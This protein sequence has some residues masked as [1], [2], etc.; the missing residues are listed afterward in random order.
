MTGAGEMIT[1]ETT[2]GGAMT[3]DVK[4]VPGTHT[5]PNA[6]TETHRP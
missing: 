5:H 6:D 3:T 1:V 4:T 2:N